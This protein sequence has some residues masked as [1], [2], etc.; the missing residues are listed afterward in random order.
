MV[1]EFGI[2]SV[3]KESFKEAD[4]DHRPFLVLASSRRGVLRFLLALLVSTRPWEPSYSSKIK[5]MTRLEVGMGGD[6]LES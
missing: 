4:E 1:L 3:L 2:L 5:I 6:R